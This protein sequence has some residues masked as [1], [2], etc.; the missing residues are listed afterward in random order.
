MSFMKKFDGFFIELD[1]IIVFVSR[2]S[3]VRIV[4]T[5]KSGIPIA[6]AAS[7]MNAFFYRKLNKA[8]VF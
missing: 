1:Q 5:K 4:P 8:H 6:S 7:S 2:F 3:R